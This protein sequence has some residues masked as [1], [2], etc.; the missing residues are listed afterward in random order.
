MTTWELSIPVLAREAD[1]GQERD[2]KEYAMAMR[3]EI[4]AETPAAAAQILRERLEG[5]CDD[6]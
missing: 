1:K 3:F 4:A 2:T 5:I 6:P